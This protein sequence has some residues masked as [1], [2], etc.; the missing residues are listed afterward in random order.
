MD[1]NGPE[2]ILEFELRAFR[3]HQHLTYPFVQPVTKV[4]V[5]VVVVVVEVVVPV[6]STR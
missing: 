2:N 1:W 6:A 4:V 5:V 3:Y